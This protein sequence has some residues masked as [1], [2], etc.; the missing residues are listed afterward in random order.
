MFEA[1]SPLGNP[2]RPKKGDDDP[3]VLDDP[4][5]NDIANKHG[6]GP[7]LV[8]VSASLILLTCTVHNIYCKYIEILTIG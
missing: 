8:S 5:I 2:G 1:Y 4:V 3:S 7:A 6:V